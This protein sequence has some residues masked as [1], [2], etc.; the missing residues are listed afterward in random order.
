MMQDM[1]KQ[2]RAADK[3][4]RAEKRKKHTEDVCVSF[5]SALSARDGGLV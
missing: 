5:E 1:W 2:A 3:E 4:R